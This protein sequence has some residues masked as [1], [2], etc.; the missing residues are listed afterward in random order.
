MKTLW[1]FS[2]HTSSMLATH[3]TKYLSQDPPGSVC[4]C[5][6][7]VWG[8]SWAHMEHPPTPW[9][10]PPSQ[11]IP[12]GQ[13][14]VMRVREA[15][16]WGIYS[17]QFRNKSGNW[18]RI[19]FNAELNIFW[20]QFSYCSKQAYCIQHCDFGFV[21]HNF[22]SIIQNVQV[23]DL[24]E[25]SHFDHFNALSCSWL[26]LTHWPNWLQDEVF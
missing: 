17:D 2:V 21:T 22:V 11:K 9:H 4:F 6:S 25:G 1:P 23:A 12:R 8:H 24:Q 3:F 20:K 16:Q 26:T 15:S 7:S 5:Y 13:G 14:R 10:T 18:S 19:W